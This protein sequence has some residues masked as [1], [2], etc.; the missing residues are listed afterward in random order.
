MSS[1][2]QTAPQ[3]NAYFARNPLPAANQEQPGPPQAPGTNALS[4]NVWLN[5]SPEAE[6]QRRHPTTERLL[7][8]CLIADF[9]LSIK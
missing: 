5:H 4:R 6:L 9:E 2:G 1:P 3:P 8:R 7:L